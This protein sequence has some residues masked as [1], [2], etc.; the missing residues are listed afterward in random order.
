MQTFLPATLA[1]PPLEFSSSETLL[2]GITETWLE[3]GGF[4][5]FIEVISYDEYKSR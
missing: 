5:H 1:K 3:K 2:L 4:A